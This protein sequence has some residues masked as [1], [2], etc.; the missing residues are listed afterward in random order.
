MNSMMFRKGV[1]RKKPYWGFNGIIL[2]EQGSDRSG[3]WKLMRA[4]K[5]VFI[6]IKIIDEEEW[7]K[8]KEENKDR[9]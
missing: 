5:L 1:P 7:M 4:D 2:L 6:S 9:N 8:G 3:R